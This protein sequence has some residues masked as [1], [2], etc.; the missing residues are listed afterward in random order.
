MKM[1]ENGEM[2]VNQI[3]VSQRF[4]RKGQCRKTKRFNYKNIIYCN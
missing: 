4:S 1:F 3:Y 2:S